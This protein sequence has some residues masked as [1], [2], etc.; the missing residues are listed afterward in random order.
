MSTSF[1]VHTINS[2]PEGS[3][4]TLEKVKKNFGMVPNLYGVLAE[5]PAAVE[6]YSE[7]SRIVNST[8]F[9]S[10]ERHVIWLTIN[11]Y[12]ECHY[13]MAAH[14]MM[15]KGDKV[16]DAIIETARNGGSYEDAKLEALRVFTL[17]VV[18]G[19]GWVSEQAVNAFIEAGF[20][21]AQILEIILISAQ[22][23]I[24]NYTNHFAHTPV[25][26]PFQAFEWQPATTRLDAANS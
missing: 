18:E 25:D 16:D 11:A 15:A 20:N 10:T 19:R 5:A 3:K 26:A 1:T 6:A 22:K 2:A 23:V 7:L 12:H 21:Q 14:T 24:S 8:S 13:C 4:A 9:S 17:A